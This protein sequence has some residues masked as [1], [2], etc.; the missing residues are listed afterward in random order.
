MAQGIQFT[1]YIPV[2]LTGVNS[3]SPTLAAEVVTG[4]PL[5]TGA[6]PGN[7]FFLTEQQAQQLS[8]NVCHSGWY[9]VVQVDSGAV[10]GNISFGTI[11]AQSAV[12]NTV[13]ANAANIPPQSI[14][15]DGATA[16]TNGTLALNPVVYLGAVTPGNF[17]IVQI[18]GDG[19][20]TAA[21][22]Q[23]ITK[24]TSVLVAA[25][26]GTV[27][28]GSTL[29]A[30][31]VGLAE[32]T[33]T[34]PAA[35]L[36]VTAVAASSNGVAVYTVTGAV[37][38]NAGLTYVIAGFTGAFISNNGTYLAS[39]AGAGTLTLNNPNAVAVTAAGTAVSQNLIRANIAFPF[40]TI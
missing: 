27:S 31:T 28:S 22:A 23:T 38:L 4:L 12:G 8:N 32:V 18:A 33:V 24:G 3:P 13:A 20:V 34:T 36:P 16:S 14:V 11:G 17:T 25:T 6:L 29:T 30:L 40:G 9:E 26:P 5:P 7:C 35:S 10:A 39:A 19:Q 37:A 2:T 1:N 15:T 21:A